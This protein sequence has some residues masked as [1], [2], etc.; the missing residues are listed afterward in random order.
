MR[1]DFRRQYI[2]GSGANKLCLSLSWKSLSSDDGH[3]VPPLHLC[4]GREK[5]FLRTGLEIEHSAVPFVSLVCFLALFCSSFFPLLRSLLFL[6]SDRAIWSGGLDFCIHPSNVSIL[7]FS[8]LCLPANICW[9]TEKT[10]IKA[11]HAFPCRYQTCE[12]PLTQISLISYCDQRNLCPSHQPP[13]HPLLSQ[14]FLHS[15]S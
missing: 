11:K 15:V 12:S 5:C 7:P 4:F 10:D 1:Q 6:W 13:L 2:T 8:L 9:L 3:C 14:L